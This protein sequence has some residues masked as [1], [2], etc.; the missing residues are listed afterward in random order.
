MSVPYRQSRHFLSDEREKERVA[1]WTG[2]CLSDNFSGVAKLGPMI[3]K[4]FRG[5]RIVDADLNIPLDTKRSLR[6]RLFFS[7]YS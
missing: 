4:L 7:F 2:H 1:T 3:Q 5:L 6:R